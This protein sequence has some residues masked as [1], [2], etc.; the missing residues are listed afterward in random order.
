MSCLTILFIYWLSHSDKKMRH[1][2]NYQSDILKIPRH[3]FFQNKTKTVLHHLSTRIFLGNRIIRW[4]TIRV[5]IFNAFQDNDIMTAVIAFSLKISCSLLLIGTSYSQSDC[6]F[7]E[8]NHDWTLPESKH[9]ELNFKVWKG[10]MENTSMEGKR[11]S[12]KFV[13]QRV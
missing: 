13:Q 4:F 7:L 2:R 3:F 5:S 11:N 8:L 12:S 6:I 9:P 10:W 1:F